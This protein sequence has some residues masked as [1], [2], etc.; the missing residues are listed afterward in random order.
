MALKLYEL[1]GADDRRFSPYSWRARLA[2]AHKGLDAELIPCRFT[3]K[4]KIAFSGQGKLPILVD[5]DTV[6]YDSWNIA[7]YL[8]ERYP[9]RPSL[10]GGEGSRALSRF[11]NHW[12][13]TQ[14]APVLFKLLAY[15]VYTRVDPADRDYFRRTREER[16]G[17]TLEQ[18]HAEREQHLPALKA[19]MAP[20]R[21]TLQENPF[22]CGD[23]PAYGDHIVLGS[24]QWAR[25]AGSQDLLERDDPISAWR[26]RMLEMFGTP[27]P[28][29]G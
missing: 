22:L 5:G 23:D 16:L 1:V 9:Y 4:D 27:E 6:V 19:V 25:L 18:V 13:D 7:S 17:K 10:F 2:L 12:A 24:L 26:Q 3:D 11:L 28:V 29:V 20:L 21:L 14:L 15:D 8:E